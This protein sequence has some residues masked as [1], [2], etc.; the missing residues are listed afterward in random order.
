MGGKKKKGRWE[1]GRTKERKQS[2]K[3]GRK[4]GREQERWER[5]D[6]GGREEDKIEG[7]NWKGKM[8]GTRSERWKKSK[9]QSMGYLPFL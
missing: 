2:K 9:C 3:E 6:G 8:E 1:E 7:W 5:W 4:K